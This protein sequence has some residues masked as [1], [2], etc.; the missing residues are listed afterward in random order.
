MRLSGFGW[1]H[2]MNSPL[3]W[4]LCL[5][6][7]GIIISSAAGCTPQQEVLLPGINYFKASQLTLQGVEAANYEFKVNNAEEILLYEGGELIA[8]WHGPPSGTHTHKITFQGMPANAI[9]TEDGKFE[10]RLEI[11]NEKGKLDKELQ[12]SVETAIASKPAPTATTGVADNETGPRSYW[13]DGLTFLS[14]ASSE[15][16]PQPKP[17]E[18]SPPMGPPTTLTAC[19]PGCAY[20]LG[21]ALAAASGFTEK[22]SEEA[23]SA[24]PDLTE[25]CYCYKPPEGWCCAGG[26]VSPAT[27]T[28][29]D[30]MSGFWSLNRDKALQACQPMC[31]CC[32]DGRIGN[33]PEAQ[34]LQMGGACFATQDQAMQAC[35]PMCWCC[36]GGQVGQTTQSQCAQM[37]GACY[38]NPGAAAAACQGAA[39]PPSEG[40]ATPPYD[41]GP[42][43]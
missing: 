21:E 15:P 34:C 1:V 12:L 42:R 30:E 37:G 33:V 5:V 29:C 23:C 9:P 40:T 7:V 6:L 18:V 26:Q 2:S 4:C 3:R 31:Y 35:Q 43:R 41:E 27:R 32:A 17:P 39:P 8:E 16:Q 10:A 19:P 38:G 36:A 13:L 11:S 25:K 20:C 22:C 24:S 14:E 28:N